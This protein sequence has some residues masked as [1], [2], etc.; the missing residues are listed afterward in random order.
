MFDINTR[1]YN[2]R[3]DYLEGYFEDE[4]D[5]TSRPEMC[6][7]VLFRNIFRWLMKVPKVHPQFKKKNAVCRIPRFLV[8]IVD[9]A[10]DCSVHQTHA[11]G[12]PAGQG[13]PLPIRTISLTHLNPSDESTLSAEGRGANEYL[14]CAIREANVSRRNMHHHVACYTLQRGE[15]H[16]KTV[17]GFC[18]R[19]GQAWSFF[20]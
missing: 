10:V 16:A 2:L 13:N 3:V 1:F 8:A 5:H 11:A 12:T 15:P 18:G 4:R 14:A 20:D 19:S 9:G 17:C 6:M 7:Y